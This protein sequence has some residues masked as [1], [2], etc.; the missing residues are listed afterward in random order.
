MKKY[1]SQI[2]VQPVVF[3]LSTSIIA[4]L[5]AITI[6]FRKRTATF[7]TEL[8]HE[9]VT[10][11]GWF[12]ILAMSGFL[13][14]IIFLVFSRFGHIRLGSDDSRPKY[15]YFTWFAMLFSA[16]MGIGLL[17]YGVAEPILHYMSPPAGRAETMHAARTAMGVTFFHW[18]L[19][20]W[21]CY[22]LVGLGLAYFSFRK[23]LPLSLRSL[24]HPLLKNHI[25]R[26]PG[27]LIDTTA[28]VSTLFGVAT[29]L[30]IGA[31]QVNAG[32]DR[33]FGLEVSSTNQMLL[34]IGITLLATISVV[35]GLDVGIRRLSEG[36]LILAGLIL[37]F[38]FLAGP[39]IFIL[40]SLVENI[41]HYLQ[42]LPSN[43]FWTATLETSSQRKWLGDWTVFY[44]AWWIAWSPFVGL[45]I[46]RVSEGRTIRE[47]IL[48]VLLVP[49]TLGFIWFS[50]FGGA[51][52]HLEMMNSGVI[53]DAVNN[54][55]STAIFAMFDQFP[56]SSLLSS[57]SVLCIM[58]FF[59]T[60]SDSASLVIDTIA[61][62]GEKNP[63]VAQRVFW[64]LTEGFVAA[65]LLVAGGLNALQTAA[66]TTALPFTIVLIVA[67]FS[68]FIA[69][70]NEKP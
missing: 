3:L 36:N 27:H 46:A 26:W 55:V 28:V 70:R 29:S 61:S 37:L 12:Y 40:N 41:G 67:A 43:S 47:F 30:G 48:G 44:W 10:S 14:F 34:I 18:G 15:S 33:V 42:T 62:G 1:L 32:L 22:S 8:Q 49:T 21:A 64:A 17:Y 2:K 16:G 5:C 7:F 58:L 68:L 38:T 52:L 63:H 23:K 59:V 24:F 39:S 60:S 69:L 51:A 13:I 19:H 31:M 6:M 25:F 54:N 53:S 45:F 56:L 4:T 9:I 65:L 35:T 20:P 11:F 57:L 66:L 50:V